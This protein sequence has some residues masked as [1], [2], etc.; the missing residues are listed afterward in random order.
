MLAEEVVATL[1]EAQAALPPAAPGAITTI[2]ERFRRRRRRRVR[3]A[4]TAIAILIL[5]VTLTS[6][7]L[8]RGRGLSPAPP[9]DGGT[10]T[11]RVWAINPPGQ[12]SALRELVA[13]YNRSAEVHVELLTFS[14]DD[15]KE[16]LRT[17][18]DS[19]DGPDVFV[20]WGGAALA[21]LAR[22]GRLADLTGPSTAGR[23]LPSAL[24]GGIVD[25][26]QYGLPMSGTHPTVLFYN[27]EV[28]ARSGRTPPR[29][30]AEL[31][32]LVDAFK[33]DGITPLALGGAQ[34]WTELMYVMYLAER[35]GG[36]GTTADIALGRPGAWTK[37]A[38]LEALR[39]A[40][41]LAERGAFGDDFS[42][43]SYDDGS[44]P[45]LL[46]TGRAAMELMGTWEYPTQLA[47][48]PDF[49]LGDQLGWVPFPA[50]AGGAGNPADLVGIPAQYFSVTARS[51]DREAALRFV[52]DVAADTYLDDL[53]TDGEVPPVTD[54]VDRLRDTDHAG[55]AISVHE[56]VAKA[57]S[58]SLAWDQALDPATAT[59]L[60]ANL[61]R[62]FRSELTPEQFAAVMAGGD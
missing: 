3:I 32:S 61:Q 27:K 20:S 26:R 62:L 51:R 30:Y 45:R 21:R 40:R 38:V 2:R 14:N 9:A 49:V 37:P 52:R 56:L 24:A 12:T 60:N 35:I 57:P 19:P 33:A 11:I 50:V 29:S 28:F 44:A 23:F 18:V 1:A 36:P 54:A 8:T 10:A 31:V 6:A 25:G 43:L 59:R 13:R 39:S 46:A 58:Y 55:F 22:D 17:S 34:G 7:E 53:V 5:A 15:Y 42:S 48:N 16:K 41:D 47:R 4:S